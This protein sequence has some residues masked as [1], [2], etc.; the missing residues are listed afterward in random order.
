[1]RFDH[2]TED[3]LRFRR[4][5]RGALCAIAAPLLLLLGG[6]PE[7]PFEYGRPCKTDSDCG[8]GYRCARVVDEPTTDGVCVDLVDSG[9]AT[10]DAAS[11]DSAV[12]DAAIADRSSR[13]QARVD[14]AIPDQARPDAGG[15][16]LIASDNGGSDLVATDHAGTDAAVPPIAPRARLDQSHRLSPAAGVLQNGTIRLRGRVIT[17]SEATLSSG[18]TTI[19]GRISVQAR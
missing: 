8:S 1:M 13:D 18:S 15:S 10:P 19:N 12:V 9:N 11:G 3:H 2:L 14:G 16:D 7:E 4:R 17:G 6:C 5:R